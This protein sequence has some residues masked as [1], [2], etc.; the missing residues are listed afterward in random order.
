MTATRITEKL[1]SSVAHT[2]SGAVVS[3]SDLGSMTNGEVRAICR[4][5][6]RPTDGAAAKLNGVESARLE[7]A[8]VGLVIGQLLNRGIEMW[9]PVLVAVNGYRT[10]K[11]ST[12]PHNEKVGTGTYYDEDRLHVGR[13]QAGSHVSGETTLRLRTAT[14]KAIGPEPIAGSCRALGPIAADDESADRSGTGR[15]GIASAF[16]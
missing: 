1:A 5:A 4:G 10:R 14:V 11:V 13:G 15:E 3:A 2:V 12:T 6:D 8:D 16:L 7:A 9:K